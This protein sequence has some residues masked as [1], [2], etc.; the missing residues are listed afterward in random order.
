MG[1]IDHSKF[2]NKLKHPHPEYTDTKGKPQNFP[3]GE[4]RDLIV[5]Q[6]DDITSIVLDQTFIS[7]E[8]SYVSPISTGDGIEEIRYPLSV[9]L[10]ITT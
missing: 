5:E 4:K 9:R 1:M 3:S 8:D 6:S 10:S 7:P 2:R